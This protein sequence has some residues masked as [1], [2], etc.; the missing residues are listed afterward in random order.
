MGDGIAPVTDLPHPPL[1]GDRFCLSGAFLK[2][3]SVL[4]HILLIVL[5]KSIFP[6]FF[7]PILVIF[8]FSSPMSVK[9]DPWLFD[10]RKKKYATPYCA[11]SY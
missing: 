1:I 2:G 11:V 8:G 7:L 4:S 3:L 5:Y 6:T 9:I 10:I